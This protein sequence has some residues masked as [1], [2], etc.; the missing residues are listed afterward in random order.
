M[1]YEIPGIPGKFYDPGERKEN[2]VILWRFFLADGRRR[3]YSTGTTDRQTAT[4]FALAWLD[5]HGGRVPD[6]PVTYAAASEAYKAWKNPRNDDA[7]WLNRL[8]ERFT[9]REVG[10]IVH[11]DLV[12]AANELLPG[13][14]NAHKNRCIMDIGGRVLHYAH[15]QQWCEYRRIKRF[16]VSRKSP[17]EPAGDDTISLLRANTEG[18]ERAMLGLLFETGL[19]ITAAVTLLRQKVDSQNCRVLSP[20]SKTDDIIWLPI[21]QALMIELANLPAYR[22]GKLFPWRDRHQVYDWLNPLCKR[23]NVYYTPHMSRHAMATDMQR[24]KIPDKQAAANGAWAD[25]RSLQRYQSVIPE[26]IAGRTIQ[27][28]AKRKR[29]KAQ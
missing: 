25:P 26:P 18:A 15:E 1:P 16:W 9:D 29:S 20:L 28:L 27:A 12:A 2:T 19:R 4:R 17:R 5:A 10:S 24:R 7:K 8:A 11:A 14:S 6:A 13:A 23:L 3:E 22:H 21:S